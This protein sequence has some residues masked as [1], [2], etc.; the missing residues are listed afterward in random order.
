MDIKIGLADSPR[1]LVIASDGNQDDI[2]SQVTRAIEGG[3]PTV[4]MSDDRGRKYVVRTEK[5]SYVEVGN[6]TARTVGFT[7]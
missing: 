1:E 2:I 4:A 3:E 6:T 5:I 7:P